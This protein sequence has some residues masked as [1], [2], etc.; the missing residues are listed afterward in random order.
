LAFRKSVRIRYVSSFLLI[1]IIPII[2]FGIFFYLYDV[3]STEIGADNARHAAFGQAVAQCEGMFDRFMTAALQVSADLES[4]IQSEDA[5]NL[6]LDSPRVLAELQASE[7]SF[8]EGAFAGFYVHG[9]DRVYLSSGIYDYEQFEKWFSSP[10]NLNMSRFYTRLNT[11]RTALTFALIYDRPPERQDDR[12]GVFMAPVPYLSAMPSCT[13]FYLFPQEEISSGFSNTMG[14]FRGNVL[15]LSR[16]LETVYQS[17]LLESGP[18]MEELLHLKGTGTLPLGQYVVLRSVAENSGR[19]YMV[20]MERGEYYQASRFSKSV[21]L[22]LMGAL[23]L[24]CVL[25]AVLMAFY[26]YR[27]IRNLV[28]DLTGEDPDIASGDELG[29]IRAAF[30][31]SQARNEQLLNRM[32]T[33]LD[34]ARDQFLLRLVQGKVKTPEELKYYMSCLELPLEGDMLLCMVGMVPQVADRR[35][36]VERILE[37][38]KRRSEEARFWVTEAGFENY[39]LCICRLDGASADSRQAA[40]C[41]VQEFYRTVGIAGV[42][43]GVGLPVASALKLH[44]SYLQAVAVVQNALLGESQSIFYYYE[45]TME[46]ENSPH[47]VSLPSMEQSLLIES[48]RHG[49]AEM[50]LDSFN[51]IVEQ[52]NQTAASFLITQMLCFEV[53]NVIIKVFRQIHLSANFS[54]YSV[55]DTFRSLPEFQRQVAVVLEAGCT[56]VAERR[57][58]D[59]TQIRTGTLQFIQQ[60][61]CESGLS[62]DMVS[63]ALHISKARINAILKEDLGLSFSQYVTILRLGYVK[64]QLVQTPDKIQDIVTSAGYIDVSNFVRKFKNLEGITP[65]QYRQL[66]KKK[67]NRP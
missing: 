38:G 32:T 26:N 1:V 25:L 57:E 55:T 7:Q 59:D 44:E 63:D 23:V 53:L 10:P 64:K 67:P 20:T 5:F 33:Q 21:L 12:L 8:P 62:L 49:D 4:L 13:A 17:S 3:A 27:P 52:I 39:A 35:L 45:S 9:Q 28:W 41:A 15:I 50:A 6:Q 14:E 19:I 47:D 2:I 51:K 37:E 16:S 24:L 60:H 30:T 34:I 61:F 31:R 42:I 46:K 40:A 66:Y 18:D 22:A 36:T 54:Q 56:E 48:I 65:G 58:A 11:L 43:W 29:S